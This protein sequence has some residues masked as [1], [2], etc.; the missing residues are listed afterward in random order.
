MGTPTAGGDGATTSLLELHDDLLQHIFLFAD[1][2]SITTA[3]SSGSVLLRVGRATRTRLQWLER[4]RNRETVRRKLW[5]AADR[6]GCGPRT[7]AEH[8]GPVWSVALNRHYLVSG[9]GIVEGAPPEPQRGLLQIRDASCSRSSDDASFARLRGVEGEVELVLSRSVGPWHLGLRGHQLAVFGRLVNLDRLHESSNSW[10]P[11]EGGA[12]RNHTPLVCSQSASL[13][14]WSEESGR[15]YSLERST[16]PDVRTPH[17]RQ[18]A[19]PVAEAH[20]RIAFAGPPRVLDGMNSVPHAIASAT[21]A[22]GAPFVAV[23]VHC[24]VH[25]VAGPMLAPYRAIAVWRDG[26]TAVHTRLER[27]QAPIYALA[28]GAGRLASGSDDK[29]I[30]LWNPFAQ[31]NHHR[32]LTSIDTGA[33]VWALAICGDLLV[34]GGHGNDVSNINIWDLQGVPTFS[35]ATDGALSEPRQVYR[36]SRVASLR[37]MPAVGVRSLA[38]DGDRVVAGGDDGCVYVWQHAGIAVA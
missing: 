29:T 4:A 27:H 9:A 26:E 23:S 6:A 37:G 21:D 24:V 14:S 18:A 20:D 7:V 5:R 10:V 33:K 11:F 35:A 16:T 13:V 31:V 36:A 12:L 2:D 30:K 25:H 22:S 1:T 28:A 19:M 3:E 17:V 15:L 34:S 38:F 32:L 8:S